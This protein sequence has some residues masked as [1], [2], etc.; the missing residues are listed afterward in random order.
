MSTIKQSDVAPRAG[1]AEREK[2]L[3]RLIDLRDRVEAWARQADWSTRRID[4]TMRD[5]SGSYSAPGLLMQ[6]EFCRILL[7]PMNGASA[8]DEAAADLYRMPEYDDV[9][10]LYFSDG[11]WRMHFVFPG[12]KATP[13][14]SDA[15]S[16]PLSQELLIE[17]LQ[18]LSEH[19]A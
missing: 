2:V 9:A 12:A 11:Q 18:V 13:E 7:D 4:K 19:A 17:V 14:I 10:R 6:K 3:G 16:P 15:T 1:T 5:A 8:G